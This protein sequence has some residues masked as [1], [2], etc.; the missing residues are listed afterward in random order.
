MKYLVV[1]LETK[2]GDHEQEDVKVAK[3]RKGQDPDH[4][5]DAIAKAQFEGYWDKWCCGFNTN[6]YLW[7]N[8]GGYKEITRKE[9]NVLSKYVESFIFTDKELKDVQE[10]MKESE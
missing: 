8:N 4:V 6:S 10:E 7:H 3:C 5:C 1:T 2:A 9:Y